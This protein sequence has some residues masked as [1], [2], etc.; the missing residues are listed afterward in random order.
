MTFR[1]FALRTLYLV[2]ALLLL[3]LLWFFRTTW[4]LVFLALVIAVGVSIPMSYLRRLGLPRALSVIL[5]FLGTL[6]VV[7]G[8]GY[9]LF[10]S[11]ISEFRTLLQGSEMT[12]LINELSLYYNALRERSNALRELLPPLEAQ[13]SSGLSAE[14]LSNFVNRTLSAGLPVLVSGGS[15]IVTLLAN[16]FL[17]VMLVIFFLAEPRAYIRGALYLVPERHHGRFLSLVSLL[18][19]TL[20]T[21][22]STLT[23]SITLTVTLVITLMGLLGMPNVFVVAAFAGLATFVPNIGA[24]LPVIPIAI[25]TLADD[26]SKLLLM[27]AAYLAIQLLESN[28]LTP[29]IVRRQLSIPPAATL[30]TQILAASI[31]GVLGILLAVPLLA[32]LITLI[33]ELYSYGLLGLRDR[34]VEIAL[35]EPG[36]HGKDTRF[37]QR[38]QGLR[39]RLERRK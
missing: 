15:V 4:L 26:P 21:W 35:P 6:L 12:Q 13:A 24:F 30:I 5:A 31:F 32:V 2:F 14:Q 19:S 18:Y 11:I 27:I 25:F 33:R 8:L 39:K 23:I 38:T 7:A 17:V 9:W 36:P 22:L 34:Q 28:V 20:R 29:S 10:P 1:Q 16:L 37:S 3:A